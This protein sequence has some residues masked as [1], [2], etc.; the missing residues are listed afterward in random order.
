M[1]TF[2]KFFAG[3]LILSL[4]VISCKTPT[5]KESNQIITFNL[6]YLPKP[7]EVKLSDLGFDNIEYVPMETSEQCMI[8]MINDI[9]L[10]DNYFL[11]HFFTNVYMFKYDG[12][13]VTKIGNEGRGPNEFTVVHDLDI[14]ENNQDIYM[15]DGWQKKFYVFSETGKFIKTL[16]APVLAA[17]VF[18]FTNNGILG[19]NSNSFGN[20]ENSY[21]LID[22][23]GIIIKDFPNMYSWKKI[24]NITT[25]FDE[26]LF[27]RFNKKLYKKEVYSDTIYVFEN[28]E[29][30]PHIIIEH[31][32]KLLSPKARSEY[33]TE[34]LSRKFISQKNLFEFGNF[35]Y[36]EFT[37]DPKIRGNN[38]FK[39]FIGSKL[40]NTQYFFDL[41]R[42]IINDL[43]GGPNICPKSVK[44]DTTI[45]SWIDASKL[46]AHV[47]SAG[48]KNS[49]PK[50]PDKKKDLER[51]AS[52]L[53]ETDN[54]VLV[55][56][57]L[58]KPE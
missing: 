56:V 5:T 44:D 57:R 29:F 30:K 17:I 39:G 20:I 54:P 34:T 1:V 51:M 48:F 42:G 28:M 11:I 19:Y 47:A 45:V 8:P 10:G 18:R 33:D 6:K 13:F 14:N 2:F 36:Y 16:R 40:D 7:S 38:T 41:N 25:I 26:N 46:K 43:D 15:I 49:T 23:S 50:Y 9:R 31:G 58:K 32:D 4:L 24:Q 52:S 53:K 22:T 27:Y 37:Y 55:I 21:N 3:A 35:I 12:K